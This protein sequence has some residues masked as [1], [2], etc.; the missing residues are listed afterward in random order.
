MG[1]YSGAEICELVGIYILSRLST[2]IDKKDWGH[3]RDD[4]LLVL[5]NVNKQQ[6]VRV[7][8][9]VIQLFKDTGFLIDVVTNLKIV[10]F[11]DITLNLNNGMFKPYKKKQMIHCCI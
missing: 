1:S 3:Y 4:D 10:N 11:L 5:R 8:K 9:S 6:I 7:R 2:I